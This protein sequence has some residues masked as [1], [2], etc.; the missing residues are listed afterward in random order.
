M[1]GGVLLFV[2]MG[3]GLFAGANLKDF[4][5]KDFAARSKTFSKQTSPLLA[6]SAL[7]LG[8]L[9]F[10][11]TTTALDSI[12]D[13]LLAPVFVPLT[14]LFFVAIEVGMQ[15]LRAVVSPR[16]ISVALAIGLVVWLQYP[17]KD[18][19]A[20]AMRVRD[21]G[22]QF[23]DPGWRNSP[24]TAY[25]RATPLPKDCVLVSNNSAASY[26]LASLVS[27]DSPAKRSYN[28]PDIITASVD[29]LRGVW[30][31]GDKACLI[32]YDN[33]NKALLFSPRE[34]QTI[35]NLELLAEFEDGVIYIATPK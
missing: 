8:M 23:T 28:S 30:P 32:W 24:M 4:A 33:A 1:N 18:I 25:L 20:Y 21:D 29:Q 3:I 7:Y 17:L 22:E 14:I 10:A 34:L 11:A 16:A 26:L 15:P 35:A 27:E 13:R 19:A 12:G 6:F 2:G 9:L 5:L 31:P